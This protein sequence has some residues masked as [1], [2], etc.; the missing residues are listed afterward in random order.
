M[1]TPTPIIQLTDVSRQGIMPHGS[2]AIRGP[3]GQ[4]YGTLVDTSEPF[5]ERLVAVV[6]SHDDMVEALQLALK[7][8]SFED[9][10]AKLTMDTLNIIRDIIERNKL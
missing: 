6:N 1:K 8:S 9:G 4:Y 2:Y 5:R 10:H 3:M 7:D